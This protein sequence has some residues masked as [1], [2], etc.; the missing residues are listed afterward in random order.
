MNKRIVDVAARA[1]SIL[2]SDPRWTLDEVCQWL[3]GRH[4]HRPRALAFAV[5]T[6]AV[7]QAGLTARESRAEAEAML[8]CR[9]R[10]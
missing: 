9:G 2:A 3:A 10:R 5:W 4:W 8:R 7:L 1:L 6:E